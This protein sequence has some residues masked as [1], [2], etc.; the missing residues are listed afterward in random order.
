[1]LG[2]RAK[3]AG[4]GDSKVSRNWASTSTADAA[5]ATRSTWCRDRLVAGQY[6]RT[7]APQALLVS[8][9]FR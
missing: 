7:M 5:V 8:T 9:V 3:G 6:R 2:D 1:M 4:A